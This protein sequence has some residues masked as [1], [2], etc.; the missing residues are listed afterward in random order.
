MN[1]TRPTPPDGDT[2]H[3]IFA[4]PEQRTAYFENRHPTYR[5]LAPV[6][7]QPAAPAPAAPALPPLPA[8][9]DDLSPAAMMD[10][11]KSN[12]AGFQS[13]AKFAI[14]RMTPSEMRTL[15]ERDP[16]KFQALYREK[17]GNAGSQFGVCGD[18][19]SEFSASEVHG[20]S[21][22]RAANFA[23]T[24]PERFLRIAG[25]D[26]AKLQEERTRPVLIAS[27]F[28][29]KDEQQASPTNEPMDLRKFT[30]RQ[31][32]EDARKRDP[33]GYL[34]AMRRYGRGE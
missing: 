32:H 24:Y 19:I 28:I 6:E 7:S 5:R 12:P 16:Q 8:S 33:Q 11:A 22:Q 3:A 14:D 25:V 18:G 13:I 20:W 29:K 31:Q 10:L 4:D 1:D 2:L 17:Y 26:V 9:I 15:R 34:E 30:T 21:S 27:G 23:K